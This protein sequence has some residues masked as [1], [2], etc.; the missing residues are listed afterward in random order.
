MLDAF[1]FSSLAQAPLILG[2]L[3]VY[4]FR[5]PM[6]VVG[7]LGGFGAGALVSAIA[8]NLV[9]SGDTL[10]KADLVIWLMTG[11]IVFAGL[12][13]IVEK[14][15][16]EQAG[17]LGIVLGSI[18]DGV[19]ESV[20]FGIQI[21]TATAISPAFLTAVMISN[22]PQAIAPSADLAENGWK[23]AKVAGMWAAVV[24]IAGI[25]RRHDGAVGHG[26]AHLA[27]CRWRSA[28]Y[29]DHL[30]HPL[31]LG[32]GRSGHR[33]LG[34]RRLCPVVVAAITGQRSGKA[35]RSA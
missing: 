22:I 33:H 27:L 4:W 26:C 18:I 15:F 2:G 3:I 17:A 25:Y 1:L 35:Y 6:R 34:C 31:F 5:I 9:V 13:A 23:W 11:A 20:I 19:P 8:Y 32:A 7:W 16:G 21:A 24:V 12:D 10:G 28:R 29:V 14:R 30:A